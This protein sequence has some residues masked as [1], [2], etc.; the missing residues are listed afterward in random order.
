MFWAQGFHISSQ[1]LRV[2]FLRHIQLTLICIKS[3]KIAGVDE[4][5]KIMIA[6]WDKL[7][8]PRKAEA[9]NTNK[10][11]TQSDDALL[12]T[13]VHD[14]PISGGSVRLMQLHTAQKGRGRL[15]PAQRLASLGTW[16]ICCVFFHWLLGVL[17]DSPLPLFCGSDRAHKNSNPC[18]WSLRSASDLQ[19]Q[20]GLVWE[21]AEGDKYN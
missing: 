10:T 18:W 4:G 11:H 9:W 14:N 2:R 5:F 20:Q 6:P 15:R 3:A 13:G 12:G 16:C 19:G 8:L 1:C 7:L 17:S 21:Q